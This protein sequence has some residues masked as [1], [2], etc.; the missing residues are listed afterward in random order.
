MENESWVSVGILIATS[1]SFFV[2]FFESLVHFRDS[3]RR[4]EKDETPNLKVYIQ[5]IERHNGFGNS[6]NCYTSYRFFIQNVGLC[7]V[8]I[9]ACEVNGKQVT[10]Y[11]Q[12]LVKPEIIIGAILEPHNS[13]NCVLKRSRALH[14]IEAGSTVKLVYKSVLGKT[15]STILTLSEEQE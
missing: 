9:L 13:I 3:R 6:I 11:N 2:A 12:E 8:T 4:K 15:Y 5:M 14:Q 10:E 1:L 7:G